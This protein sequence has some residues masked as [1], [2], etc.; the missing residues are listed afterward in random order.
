MRGGHRSKC[1]S[2]LACD[3]SLSAYISIAAVTATYGSALT[4]GH[5][6]KGPKVT[7]RP[8]PHHSAPRLGSVCPNAGFAAWAAAMGH[9]WPSAANPASCRV[10]HAAKP[11]F[12][13]RGLT[14]RFQIKSRARRP[15]SR[16]GGAIG[17]GDECGG[18]H[19][20]GNHDA[21]RAALALL[22][23]LGAP[24]NHAGR[25]S[26]GIWGVNRQ[27]CR[28]SRPAPWMARGGGPPNHW[29]ITGTPSLGEVPSG[30]ARA[31]CLLLRFSK[32]SRCKSGTIG[33]RCRR[34]GYVLIPTQ[35]NGRPEGRLREQAR[36]HSLIAGCPVE[37]GRLSGRH[38]R[39]ASSH[40]W[41]EER[42]V[43]RGR[44][45]V[46]HGS[47]LPHHRS[48]V[49]PKLCRYLCCDSGLSAYI[50]IPAVTA[51]Y[52][53]ALT[54]GHFWK[55]PKVTKRPSPHHAAKPAFGQR[56]LTGRFQIKS[57][58]RR[59]YSRPVFEGELSKIFGGKPAPRNHDAKRAALDLD[60][61]LILSAP[62]NHAG[63][64]STGI[65]G[66]NRQGCRFSRPA[67]W[68][69]R[70]G[71]PPN[72]WRITGTPSP[73]EVP[74]GGARAFCLLL[75]FSKVSRCKSGTIGGRCRRNGY[76]LIPTQLNGRPEGRHRRQASSH[77]WTEERQVDRGRLSGLY[78]GQRQRA[79]IFV[80]NQEANHAN[81]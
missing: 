72:H 42:Q 77:I 22:L 80:L 29:R 26:T 15:Y 14:G 30:G 46:R 56:G 59:P 37:G 19:A 6:W 47:K 32:V 23:I 40:I 54:A 81:V 70:G 45:S 21:K 49:A 39:Q 31:F 44:L 10:T 64:N 25:N 65:W 55:G 69:A 63:R 2:W 4:A 53:S 33:G 78:P 8:S 62:L 67:P 79:T 57:R 36:S 43:D 9:P 7:K 17:L 51:T 74:S 48:S 11:A 12:G 13:Q 60:L 52:G 71:G 24:L 18:R 41:T 73:S 16:P 75:R 76:V 5:F 3:S 34:N 68:M 28:F 35:L 66:V 20:P 1:G 38:R 27:G 50:S 58:A 61:P